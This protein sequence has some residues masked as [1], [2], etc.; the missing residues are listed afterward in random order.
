MLCITMQQASPVN[1]QQSLLLERLVLVTDS[2]D[3]GTDNALRT[4]KR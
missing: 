4:L 3:S 1:R 2:Y